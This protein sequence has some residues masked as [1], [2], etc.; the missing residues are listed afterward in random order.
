MTAIDGS[1]GTPD[2]TRPKVQLPETV[3][4]A[5]VTEELPDLQGE[6]TIT[7]EDKVRRQLAG[8]LVALLALVVVAAFVLLCL[9]DLLSIEP[10]DLQNM[11][12]LFFTSVLTLVS[13]VLG[14]YFGAKK[15]AKD[16]EG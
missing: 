5:E 2:P 11:V 6:I 9:S 7:P 10:K 4:N 1:A 14:F 13:T 16:D 8:W 3:G 12:Q 15:R